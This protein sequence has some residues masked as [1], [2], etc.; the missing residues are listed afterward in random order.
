MPLVG[1]RS[2]LLGLVLLILRHPAFGLGKASVEVESLQLMLT[3]CVK[4]G[5]HALRFRVLN[6]SLSSVVERVVEGYVLVAAHLVGR[7]GRPGVG[8]RFELDFAL[9]RGRRNHL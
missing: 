9:V 7:L 5:M 8:V 3:A 2:R 4:R 1:N 6:G